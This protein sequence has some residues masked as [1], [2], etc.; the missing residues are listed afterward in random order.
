[1]KGTVVICLQDLVKTKFDEEHW[2]NILVKSGLS[3][4]L[5]FYCHHNIDDEIIMK[6]LN[7]TC[8]VLGL[9]LQQMADIFG[10]YWIKE[11]T[12]K[13][14]FAFYTGKKSAKEFLLNMDKVHVK[15]TEK[16]ENAKPPRFTYEEINEK[17]IIMTYSSSRNLQQIWIGIIKGVGKYFNEK[18]DIEILSKNS[19]KLTFD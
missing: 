7:N 15:M 19:V 1:M 18:I 3:K 2:K 5:K 14:Y 13:K 10:E 4:D 12:S 6:L 9:T 11:F 17:T 16:I 8:E